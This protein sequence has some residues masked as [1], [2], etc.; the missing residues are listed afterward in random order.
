M[1]AFVAELRRLTEFFDF[2]PSLEDMLRDRLVC[3]MGDTR[4]QRRLLAEPEMNFKKAF[5]LSSA[6]EMADR[7]A[8]DLQP[9]SGRVHAMS[10]ATRKGQKKTGPASRSEPN[11]CGRCGGD[12]HA[13]DCRFKEAIC[14]RCGKN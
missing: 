5:D 1:A 10:A 11:A 9:Q 14:R 12:H 2:G 3:G 8:A 7:D 13:N 6:M 4:M